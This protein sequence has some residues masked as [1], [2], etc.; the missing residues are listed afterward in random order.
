MVL[1]SRCVAAALSVVGLASAG[2]AG[3]ETVEIQKVQV[4]RSVSG[5]ASDPSGAPIAGAV[6]A[7]LGA[8][9]KTVARTVQTDKNGHFSLPA[10]P[11]QRIY[12]L[13]ISMK[14]FNPLIVHVKTSRWSRKTLKLRLEV[15]T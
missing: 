15:G 14:G 2:L 7:E 11:H 9:G 8:D 5:M 4:V 1:I 10:R 6:I 13:R 3:I 12:S